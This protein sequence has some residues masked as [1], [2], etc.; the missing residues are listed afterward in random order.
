MPIRAEL[1]GFYGVVGL[2]LFIPLLGGLVAAFGGLEGLASLFGVDGEIVMPA[3]LR[4]DY[5]AIPIAFFSW[6]PLLIWS[7]A[8][9]PERTA[10]FRIIIGCG[11]LA[12][13]ARL[14]GYLVEGYPGVE[15]IVLMII[16]FVGMPIMLLWHAR[17]VR[18]IRQRITPI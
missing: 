12:G 13:F 11:F 8:A 7:L 17:L 18:L 5:R 3:S 14:T 9:L 6:V 15:A 1:G 10:V 2:L 4:S 16:E